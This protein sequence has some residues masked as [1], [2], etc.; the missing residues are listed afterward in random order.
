[1]NGEPIRAPVVVK[2]G[3]SLLADP[4][5]GR[6]QRWCDWLTGECA[7]RC[8]VV[9]GGGPFADAVRASQSRWEFSDGT[10]HR[11]ALRAMDQYALMLC[12]RS[13]AFVAADDTSQMR[14]LCDAGRT[15]VWMPAR[16]LDLSLD[17]PRD[18]RVTS[19]SLA[20]W[21]AQRLGLPRVV[22]VKSCAIPDAPLPVLSAGGIVDA[23]LPT[24]V[25]RAGIELHLVQ[26]DDALRARDWLG[27]AS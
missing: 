3:G 11:M 7:G 20:V 23:W 12:E 17:L 5:D 8:I 4:A 18:W 19:D 13:A 22:L 14:A 15:P 24:L 2:L 10:A 26:A 9:A 27:G 6:L 25:E 16:E 1:M 21:L